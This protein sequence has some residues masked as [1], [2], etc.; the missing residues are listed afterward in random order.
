MF[1]VLKRSDI[2][3]EGTVSDI[4]YGDWLLQELAITEEEYKEKLIEK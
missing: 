3:R 1:K 2:A 4:D